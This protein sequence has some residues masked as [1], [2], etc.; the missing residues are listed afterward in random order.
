M[1]RE[2]LSN[3]RPALTFD[4]EVGG[5]RYTA[6]VGRFH[7]GR[8]GEVFLNN[9]RSNSAADVNARDAAIVFS[10]AVQ[11]GADPEAVRR[12]LSRDGQGRANGPLGVALD[13]IAAETAP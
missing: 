4:L 10:F 13:L 5:L 2:R 9:H 11:H 3:R 7:D 12:A 6:T 8:I 1:T